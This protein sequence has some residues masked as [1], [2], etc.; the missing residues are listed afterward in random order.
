MLKMG[1]LLNEVNIISRYNHPNI[2][3][4]HTCWI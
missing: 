2:I 4:F 1:D 3:R